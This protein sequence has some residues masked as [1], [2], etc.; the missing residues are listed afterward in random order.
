MLSLVDP[1]ADLRARAA[2]LLADGRRQV[3]ESGS[4]VAEVLAGSSGRGDDAP[5]WLARI[6]DVTGTAMREQ[7]VGES[8]SRFGLDGYRD[9]RVDLGEVEL[10]ETSMLDLGTEWA[11]EA[12]PVSASGGADVSLLGADSTAE[13][14]LSGQDGL[15]AELSGR[16]YLAQ[17]NAEGTAEWGV[18]E[19]GAGAEA[20]AGAE[21]GVDA[22][23]GK[24]GLNVGAEAFVGARGE[25]TAHADVGGVGVGGAAEGW[26]GAG[27]EGDVTLGKNDDGSWTIGA[28][29]GVAL[30]PGGKLA[31]EVTVDPSEVIDTAASAAD[32]VGDA[33]GSL[34][35]AAGDVGDFVSSVPTPW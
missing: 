13:F 12:G 14:S 3:D 4:R 25:V 18:A 30:G 9:W 28:E 22:S 10:G 31:F 7:G 1:G 5:G 29:G 6:A 19:V 2:E 33:A 24:D 8:A 32:A 16:T 21:A 23:V 15:T 26:V 27:V 20:F 35:D 11:A 17:A 34:R